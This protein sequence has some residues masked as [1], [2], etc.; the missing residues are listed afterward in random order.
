MNT[1]GLKKRGENV[2]CCQML[3]QFGKIGKIEI[4]SSNILQL[5]PTTK[6]IR[7]GFFFYSELATLSSLQKAISLMNFQKVFFPRVLINFI[8]LA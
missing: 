7:M 3:P 4:L 8:I 1:F 2:N 5:I 6:E